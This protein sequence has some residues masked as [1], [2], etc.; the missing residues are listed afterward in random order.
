MP[1]S[2]ECCDS[3]LAGGDHFVARFLV[4][5]ALRGAPAQQQTGYF[6][7]IQDPG[8]GSGI[9]IALDEMLALG[10]ACDL[11]IQEGTYTRAAGLK[12]YTVP[13]ACRV[14][15]PGGAIIIGNEDA[16]VFE[17]AGGCT[18]ERIRM[19][20]SQAPTAGTA[21]VEA[22][23]AGSERVRLVDLVLAAGNFAV[24]GAQLVAGDFEVR[25][26]T[27]NSKN[28][29]RGVTIEGAGATNAFFDIHDCLFDGTSSAVRF[30]FTG[31]T[32][33]RDSRIVNN[34]FVLGNAVVPIEAGGSSDRCMAALNVS[35]GSG[36]TLPTDAGTNNSINPGIANIWGP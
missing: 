10:F 9:T 33:V 12:R 34:R 5:N 23:A 18:V 36:S 32:S 35:R 1:V 16:C 7:Y 22:P 20:A 21:L 30:G 6:R 26:C 17:L 2:V 3:G 28:A 11:C 15:S 14:W 31:G 27:F 13:S 19:Q 24:V 29:Q 8:D 25:G 4:G